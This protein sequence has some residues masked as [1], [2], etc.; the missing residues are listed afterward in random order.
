M[1]LLRSPWAWC[2]ASLLL[3][4][5]VILRISLTSFIPFW[6][7]YLFFT[8]LPPSYRCLSSWTS[9]IC[10]KH[11]FRTALMCSKYLWNGTNRKLE[12]EKMIIC[13]LLSMIAEGT[14]PPSELRC[15]WFLCKDLDIDSALPW[16]CVWVSSSLAA[17]SV[18]GRVGG[19]ERLLSELRRRGLHHSF[20]L[21]GFFEKS[22]RKL[23]HKE[24]WPAVWNVST[25]LGMCCVWFRWC[26]SMLLWE[27][28]YQN[29]HNTRPS[30]MCVITRW[31]FE[32][33]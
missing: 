31:L 9:T 30:A 26:R 25:S 4:L 8:S 16:L 5:Q 15:A 21:A 28:I 7:F 24:L 10:L 2:S 13:N 32:Q 33:M 17:G 19:F 18:E 11:I 12:K 3:W 29:S 14:F 23:H 1:G 27:L 6:P 20:S 22:D